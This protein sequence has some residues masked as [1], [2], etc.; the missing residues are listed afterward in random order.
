MLWKHG[1][2]P[3]RTYILRIVIHGNFLSLS[4]NKFKRILILLSERV[5]SAEH[6]L[7][8]GTECEE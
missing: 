1:N 3:V 2:E 8:V 6:W 4:D 7:L 5:L